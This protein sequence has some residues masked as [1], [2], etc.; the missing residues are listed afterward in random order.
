MNNTQSI[1]DLRAKLKAIEENRLDELTIPAPVASASK[2]VLQWGDDLLQKV[3]PR[4]APKPAVGT[5]ATAADGLIYRWEGGQWVQKAGQAGGKGRVA[6]SATASELSASLAPKGNLISRIAK[7]NPKLSTALATAAAIYVGGKVVGPSNSDPAPI[8]SAPNGGSNNQPPAGQGGKESDELAALKEQID[9]LI[10]ELEPTTDADVKK[11]LE[12]IK[13]KYA[14][15]GLP[16]G[17]GGKESNIGSRTGVDFSKIGSTA[18]TGQQ[19]P[20]QYQIDST[21]KMIA[22][23][24]ERVKY[25]SDARQRAIDSGV[26]P[27]KASILAS[28]ATDRKFG[29]AN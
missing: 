6:T 16:A 19:S 3:F 12:R 9:A 5:E 28:S 7:K 23:D 4:N 17:Q 11:E 2:K 8:A 24:P 13:A 25:Y 29:R 22:S 10:K 1:I 18:P 14:G 26:D 27:V 15:T 20:E 21:S